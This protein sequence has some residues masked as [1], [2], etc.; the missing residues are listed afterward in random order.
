[1]FVATIINSVLHYY[2]YSIDYD[3]AGRLLHELTHLYGTVD[4]LY[5]PD[6]TK[7]LSSIQAASN[8][9]TYKIHTESV[10]LGECTAD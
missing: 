2:M 1:M 3:K 7:A 4:Y 8:T 9:D 5:E 10:R 6:T